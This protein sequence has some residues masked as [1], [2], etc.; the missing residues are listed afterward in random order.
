MHYGLGVVPQ[1]QWQYS[2]TTSSLPSSLSDHAKQEIN[3]IIEEDG[4][5][6]R[7]KAIESRILRHHDTIQQLEEEL[8]ALKK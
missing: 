6:T 1:W 4:K 2:R 8:N 3:N 5:E 7:I